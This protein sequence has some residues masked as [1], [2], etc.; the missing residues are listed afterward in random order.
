M[1]VKEYNVDIFVIGDDW[2]GDFFK[3]YCEVV[4]LPCIEG[5]LTIKIKDN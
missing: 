5:I 3:D 1:N 2:K 4:Y